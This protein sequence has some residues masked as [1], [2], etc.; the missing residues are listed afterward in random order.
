MNVAL[1]TNFALPL[2]NLIE[3]LLLA[4]NDVIVAV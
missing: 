4:N 2:H 1:A 3:F